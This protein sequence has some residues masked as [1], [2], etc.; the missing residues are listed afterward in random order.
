M[1]RSKILIL[2]VGL[3]LLLF[4][5]RYSFL[6]PQ[7][8]APGT[9][10]E[11]VSVLDNEP[12]TTGNTQKFD[13]NGFKIKTRH[14]PEYHY[15]DKLKIVG[16]VGH[17]HSISFPV[18]TRLE[19][20]QTNNLEAKLFQFRRKLEEVINRNLPQPQSSLLIGMLLGIKNLPYEFSSD[21]KRSGLIHIV[22]ASGSNVTI[23]ASFFLYL[24][25]FVQRRNAIFLSLVA[26]ALYTLMVGLEP[27]I[28]RAALM[29]GLSY[30]AKIFGR[31]AY[32]VLTLIL[33]ASLMLL[34]NPLYIFDLSFQL[35]F[36]ATA[37]IILFAPLF[38]KYLKGTK[39]G[40]ACVIATT[41]SAQLFV[42]PLIVSKF[43]QFPLFSL[44]T[45]LLIYPVVEPVMLLGFPFAILGVI[46]PT[47][48]QVL[49]FLLWLPLTYF[50]Q[51][52]R[53][54]SNLNCSLI[55]FPK[56]PFAIFL[57]YYLFLIHIWFRLQRTITIP[58]ARTYDRSSR[59]EVRRKGK[60]V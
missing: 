41:V 28:I 50:I 43:G 37:G 20:K 38:L 55:N 46:V 36:L 24:S 22:V 13:F 29:G 11:I 58:H 27:P 47:A 26:I 3:Y 14:Y 9:Q 51:V 35:S 42:T 8:F 45:N 57:P 16:S 17:N 53:F 18:I 5:W 52:A 1:F 39:R 33:V 6:K 19:E 25:G 10:V 54:F 59:S 44:I 12:E 7:T 31:Q 56:L 34:Y 49:S 40:L 4:S 21:L 2:A 30:L 60:N 32:Q 15:G 23:V 48:S